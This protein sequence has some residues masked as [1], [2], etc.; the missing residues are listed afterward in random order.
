MSLR[1]CG[2]TP[3][4]TMPAVCWRSTISGICA[5]AREMAALFR[6]VPGAVENTLELSSRLR[7]QLDDLGYEFPR[8][9][10]PDGETMDSF[11]RKRVAEG[12]MRR[13]GP[14]NDSAPSGAGEE[15]GGARTRSDCAARLCR[16]LPD[17][18]GHR[19]LL[20]E[21]RHPDSRPRQRGELRRLL[22]A[23]NHGYR[24]GRDGTAL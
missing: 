3:I 23:R 20:Q 10:V 5:L 11:L 17:R 18:L 21:E 8:Y 13:Y 24:S 7:F 9:P 15:A 22:C 6:D 14:K 2:I 4:S 19:L 12:V 1:R 16:I